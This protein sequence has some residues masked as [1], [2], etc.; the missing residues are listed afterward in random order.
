M[1][2]GFAAVAGAT[3]VSGAM[4]SNAQKKAANAA[5]SAQQQ[6]AEESVAEQRRQFDEMQSL[7]SPFVKGGTN[8]FGAQQTL[9]GLNGPEAQRQAIANIQNSPQF[10]ALKQ[11]GEQSILANSSAT[12]GLRGGNVQAA[13]GQFSPNLLAQ[14]IEQ[15]YGR[16]GGLSSIGQ[17]SA[18]GVGAAGIQTGQGVSQALQQAGAAQAGNALASG[19]AQANLY[20]QI[21]GTIGQLGGM[22]ASGAFNRPSSGGAMSNELF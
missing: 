15:Q 1:P 10:T 8:A 5:S 20:G 6:A 16:L 22:Y 3:I 21:G 12:G 18:A 7:L 14:L 11:A 13:L 9:A 17:A 2:W 4:S 19:Q